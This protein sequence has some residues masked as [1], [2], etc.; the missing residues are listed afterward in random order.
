VQHRKLRGVDIGLQIQ[1]APKA[2]QRLAEE[3]K[4]GFGQPDNVFKENFEDFKENFE[5]EAGQIIKDE[6]EQDLHIH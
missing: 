4:E 3:V 2:L 6:V 1:P 5:D